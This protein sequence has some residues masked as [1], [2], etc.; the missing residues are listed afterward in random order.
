[1]KK[2]F[3]TDSAAKKIR[4][5]SYN[6]FIKQLNIELAKIGFKIAERANNKKNSGKSD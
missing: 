3:E 1:M 2:I 4:K 6:V 5:E